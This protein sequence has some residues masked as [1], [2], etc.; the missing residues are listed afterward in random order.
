M[1]MHWLVVMN[2]MRLSTD[3]MRM[4]VSFMEASETHIIM[5]FQVCI[6]VTMMAIMATIDMRGIFYLLVFVSSKMAKLFVI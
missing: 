3:V 2:E 1:E 6:L 4:Q 5:V